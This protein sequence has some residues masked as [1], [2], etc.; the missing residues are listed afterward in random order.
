MGYLIVPTLLVILFAPAPASKP[1][2]ADFG[3]F[4]KAIGQQISIVDTQGVVHEGTLR[5]ASS[6]GVTMQ[7]GPTTRMF[8]SGSIASAERLR[9]R[10]FD[11]AIRGALF[12]IVYGVLASQGATNDRQALQIALGMTT[13]CAGMGFA[14][15][16]SQSHRQALYRAVNDPAPLKVSLRF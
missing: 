12:G 4:S 11:G 15:D 5:A 14:L 8:Q 10:S 3:R 6:A 16:Y 1:A 7:F 2:L 13:T 9:D